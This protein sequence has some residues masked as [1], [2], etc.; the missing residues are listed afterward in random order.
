M[1]WYEK[2]FPTEKPKKKESSEDRFSWSNN[3]TVINHDG[4][5]NTLESQSGG[6]LHINTDEELEELGKLITSHC[7]TVRGMKS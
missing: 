7:K 4:G 5:G 3:F 6:K 2:M 1:S